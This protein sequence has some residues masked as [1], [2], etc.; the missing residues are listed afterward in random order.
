MRSLRSVLYVLGVLASIGLV[1]FGLIFL[2][3]GSMFTLIFAPTEKGVQI[4]APV[5]LM[6]VAV[7]IVAGFLG[8]FGSLM[9]YQQIRFGPAL[10][11]AAGVGPLIVGALNEVLL[12][13]RA[14]LHLFQTQCVVGVYVLF[15]A[16]GLYHLWRKPVMPQV[17][18]AQ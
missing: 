17:S 12:G 13:S 9:S 2:G 3:F 4:A 1:F 11:I 15:V 8:A 5:M 6:G 14:P 18:E 7:F 16:S 10:Q